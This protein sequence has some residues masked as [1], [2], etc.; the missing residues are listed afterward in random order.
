[1]KKNVSMLILLATIGV[2]LISG[3]INGETE[4]LEN[5]VNT[6]PIVKIPTEDSLDK[7]I[8]DI[9][10]IPIKLNTMYLI[11]RIPEDPDS[12]DRGIIAFEKKTFVKGIKFTFYEN[13]LETTEGPE[14]IIILD[15]KAN[16]L[17][18][19]AIP[20]NDFPATFKNV[21]YPISKGKYVFI[22]LSQ[23]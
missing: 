9:L 2:I 15:K 13:V 11:D 12:R 16:L 23:Q 14:E 10:A 21:V 18:A 3:C 19:T 8:D 7:D 4:V 22:M 20:L 1:M 17:D 5:K 6:F